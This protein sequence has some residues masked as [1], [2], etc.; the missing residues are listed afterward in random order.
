MI[1]I[2]ISK[3]QLQP[4]PHKLNFKTNELEACKPQQYRTPP[5]LIK[6]RHP[7]AAVFNEAHE[8]PLEEARLR[9]EE[10]GEACINAE[11]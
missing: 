8:Q 7:V 9:N 2:K 1:S 4:T 5:P 6:P 3:Y 11:V 10:A